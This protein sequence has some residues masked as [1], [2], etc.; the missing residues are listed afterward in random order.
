MAS[1]NISEEIISDDII[2]KKSPDNIEDST[3]NTNKECIELKNLDYKNMLMY[4][5]NLKSNSVNV[6]IE[7]IEKLLENESLLNK[8]DMWSKLDKTDKIIKL[9]NFAKILVIRYTLDSNEENKLN[10]YLIY[11]LERK[12]I[13]K[14]KDI[15]YNKNLGIIEDI[16]NLCFNEET[17]TF[18]IKRND[19]HGNTQKSLAPKKNKTQK[20]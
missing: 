9:K 2:P 4:G 3:K 19:R 17:R 1:D 15:N 14:I 11:C 5:N 6:D 20:Y 7:Q 18:F 8:L 10:N 16:P 13:S 12:H